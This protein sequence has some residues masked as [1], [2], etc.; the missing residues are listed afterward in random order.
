MKR[1][2]V[3]RAARLVFAGLLV[4]LWATAVVVGAWGSEPTVKRIAV[5]GG[6]VVCVL[7]TPEPA[8]RSEAGLVVHLYGSGGSHKAGE[9]NV[10]R[11]TFDRFRRR[12]AERG[13]WLIVPDLGPGHWMNSPGPRQPR[14]PAAGT[15]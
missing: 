1:S 7:Y 4:S 10:G 13:Y 5:E 3:T 12:L 14:P 15:E 9:Y 8:P 11:A 2:L 6:E